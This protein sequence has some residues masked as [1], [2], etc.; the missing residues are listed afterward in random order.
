MDDWYETIFDLVGDRSAIVLAAIVF[1]SVAGLAFLVMA[2]VHSRSA[3][4]RRAAGINAH[5]GTQPAGD[6]TA[7]RQSSSKAVQRILDYASKHYAAG[8]KSDAKV[9]RN[10]L[11]HAGI[12]DQR[13]VAIFF[14]ARTGLAIGLALGSFFVLPLLVRLGDSVFWLA[15][16]GGG[17][18]GYLVPGLYINRLI[19]TRRAE[20]R[21]GFPDFM[22]LLVVCADSGLSMEASLDRV[23]REM[24]E[25]YPSLCMNIQM[26]N[27]EIR[28]GSSMSVA[29]E[30]FG[31]RIGLEEGRSFS[32]LIQQS[33]ELGSSITDALRIY[34][35]DMRHKRL[36]RAEEKAYGLPSKLALPMML[37]IFPVLFIVILLPVVVRF[38]TNTY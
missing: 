37:C 4:K 28:A 19:S 15:V 8:E 25:A 36:S 9:L 21:I 12:F 2:G 34:S 29:L 22:D 7:L 10:R 30:N 20:H 27:L 14:V 6:Q 17:L 33:M 1:L 24:G 11:I 35:E 5:S 26:T 23:G 32:V 38:A 18:L 16:S 31:E 3:V 13:G